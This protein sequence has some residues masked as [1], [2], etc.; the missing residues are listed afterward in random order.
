MTNEQYVILACL[1][2]SLENAVDN[3]SPDR[4]KQLANAICFVANL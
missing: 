4:I 1:T 2:Q 3:E